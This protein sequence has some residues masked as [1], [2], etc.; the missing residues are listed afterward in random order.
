MKSIPNIPWISLN[1]SLPSS[2]FFINISRF[3]ARGCRP[4]VV[5]KTLGTVFSDTDLPASK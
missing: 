2:P 5:L 3:S 1:T 4:Q